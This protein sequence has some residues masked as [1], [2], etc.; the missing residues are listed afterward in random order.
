MHDAA[1]RN[2]GS[3]A[4]TVVVMPGCAVTRTSGWTGRASV[5][6]HVLVLKYLSRPP[7]HLLRVRRG[8]HYVAD[9]RTIEV[10]RLVDLATLA[11]R[12]RREPNCGQQER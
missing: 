2:Q 9:C 6:E 7:R 3:G 12:R 8:L 1:P 5:V 4:K 11:P 10:A